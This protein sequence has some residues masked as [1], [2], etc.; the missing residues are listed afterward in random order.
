[1]K[2]IQIFSNHSFLSPDAVQRFRLVH[3]NIADRTELAGLKMPY[4]AAPTDCNKDGV[5]IVV[6]CKIG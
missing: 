6:V 2:Y 3:L 1:M 5:S 4:D